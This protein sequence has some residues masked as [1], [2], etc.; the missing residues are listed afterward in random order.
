MSKTSKKRRGAG[1]GGGSRTTRAPQQRLT[2]T[3]PWLDQIV[4]AES[5]LWVSLV[6]MIPIITIFLTLT[7]G[8]RHG[9]GF[10]HAPA[11]DADYWWHIA[12]GNLVLDHHRVPTTDPY[13]WTYGGKEWIAH[14]WLAEV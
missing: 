3:H 9:D 11:V 14:E 10:V 5:L 8:V 4:N 2:A 13:S 6:L 1:G 12:T 7:G